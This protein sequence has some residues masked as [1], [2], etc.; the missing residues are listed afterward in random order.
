M[1][2]ATVTFKNDNRTITID[3]VHNIET[4][5]LDYN[6]TVEPQLNNDEPLDLA[7]ILADRFLGALLPDDTDVEVVPDETD[8]DI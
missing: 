2:N 5:S 8:S 4:G 6:V 3:F 7:T 1:N